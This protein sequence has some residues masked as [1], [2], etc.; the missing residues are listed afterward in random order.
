[1]SWKEAEEGSSYTCFVQPKGAITSTTEALG[2]VMCRIMPHSNMVQYYCFVEC[3]NLLYVCC[4]DGTQR[5]N[6]LPRASGQKRRFIRGSRKLQEYCVARMHVK[7]FTK[8]ASVEVTY[9][10]TH[11]NHAVGIQECKYLPLPLSVRKDIQEKFAHGVT[12]ER[13]MSGK[14]NAH[15][16]IKTGLYN[17]ILCKIL[18]LILVAVTRGK[19]SIKLLHD[20]TSSQDRIAAMHVEKFATLQTIVTKM[21]PCQLIG[22]FVSYR[23][24]IQAQ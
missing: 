1:M 20:G 2:T 23:W 7:H 16:H 3:R 11:T 9:I 10:S 8:P 19:L 17:V 4:R 6:M 12:L 24:R 18:D 21:M 15:A 13:I 5:K 22:S 14:Y